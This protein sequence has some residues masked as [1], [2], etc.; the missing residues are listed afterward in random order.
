ML[1]M[2]RIVCSGSPATCVSPAHTCRATRDCRSEA[3]DG[4]NGAG[5]CSTHEQILMSARQRYAHSRV[6]AWHSALL[7]L[8]TQTMFSPRMHC[9]MLPIPPCVFSQL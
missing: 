5:T 4:E 6:W 7:L 2:C 8:L 3:A 1:T 9:P